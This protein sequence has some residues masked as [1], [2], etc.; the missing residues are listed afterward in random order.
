MAPY[1]EN[2]FGEFLYPRGKKVFGIRPSVPGVNTFIRGL[3]KILTEA[4]H[5]SAI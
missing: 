2:I 5:R 1:I 4:F 3:D